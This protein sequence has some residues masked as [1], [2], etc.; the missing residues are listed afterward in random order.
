M[1][2]TNTAENIGLTIDECYDYKEE[3]EGAFWYE[4]QAKNKE[5]REKLEVF[6]KVYNEKGK[7]INF[8]KKTKTKNNKTKNTM[9]TKKELSEMT[10]EELEQ[11]LMKMPELE[12]PEQEIFK[13]MHDIN[14]FQCT[15][16]NELY[17]RGTDEYGKDFT[18]C[19]DAFEFL[20]WIDTE[21]IAYIK[22]QVK[23]HVDSK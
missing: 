19:F 14:T 7:V 11:E 9:K 21:Q 4:S 3:A 18:I 2:L 20:E 6:T 10:R 15:T 5:V 23:K 12:A 16:D 8:K 13:R 1:L 17:L 22:D